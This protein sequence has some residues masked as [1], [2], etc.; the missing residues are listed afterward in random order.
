MKVGII[1]IFAALLLAL[2][3]F[4]GTV[5]PCTGADTDGDGTVDICD[6][7]SDVV[8]PSQSDGDQD[9]Y[10]DACDCDYSATG[11]FACDGSDFTAFIGKFGT[12]VPP[13]N[14]EYDHVPNGAVDGS[15][16]T[17]FIGMF[18]GVPGPACADVNGPG[19]A[20]VDPGT[21]CP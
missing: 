17:A 12:G 8:N 5:D 4:A 11:N 7:C 9:G 6:N 13:T 21:A 14:C 15:D 10:G 1:T 18:G 19:T 16:F 3:A 20:C 2:P